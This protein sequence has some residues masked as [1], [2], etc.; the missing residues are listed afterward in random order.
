MADLENIPTYS[1]KPEMGIGLRGG[2]VEA[3]IVETKIET[4]A[5]EAPKAEALKVETPAAETPKVE[6]PKIENVAI[7]EEPKTPE[8]KVKSFDE[9][10]FE[11][12][13]GKYKTYA[14]LESAL[15]PKEE[16]SEKIKRLWDLEKKGIDVTSKEFLELQSLDFD[17]MEKVDDLIFEKWKRGEEGKGLSDKTIRY[18]INKKYNVEGW[19]DK[20]D[21]ELTDDDIANREKMSRDAGVSKQWLVNYKNERVLEKQVDPSVSEAMAK[22][23]ESELQ[24]WDKFV[25]SDLVSKVNK[26]SSP[27]SYKDEAGNVVTSD[28]DYEIP[29]QVIEKFGTVMKNLPRDPNAI[30]GLF[31][32][33]KGNDD[34]I[35]LFKAL[36]KSETADERVAMAYSQGAEKRAVV[37]EKN[38]KNTDFTPSPT[39]GVPQGLTREQA[40]AKAVLEG[41]KK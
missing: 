21:S 11:K 2:A 22:K 26:L 13:G 37:L 6:T 29:K 8:I 16:P 3:P 17:K 15:T 10:L 36:V 19:I 33:A 30:F 12:T 27:I 5:A 14:E 28:F 34:P 23:A 4:P 7:I 18:E 38:A 35:A 31:K 40:I 24:N 32:D 20:E 25:D 39:G 41:M 9:E 1:L